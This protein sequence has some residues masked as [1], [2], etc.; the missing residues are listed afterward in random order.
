MRPSI[1]L[2]DP[3][4]C[5]QATSVLAELVAVAAADRKSHVRRAVLDALSPSL[6]PYLAKARGW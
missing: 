2:T 4:Y 6:D 5:M 3:P 1:S